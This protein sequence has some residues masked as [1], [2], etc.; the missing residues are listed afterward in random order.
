MTGRPLE[1]L[2]GRELALAMLDAQA[3]RGLPLSLDDA[4]L[5]VGAAWRC[6]CAGPLW[7]RGSACR[8]CYRCICGKRADP[9]G[10]ACPVC[11]YLLD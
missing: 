8:L 9:D 7:L 10:T 5:S 4:L 6:S 1:N 11:G 2:T 3:F